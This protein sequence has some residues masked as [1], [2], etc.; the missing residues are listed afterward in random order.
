VSSGVCWWLKKEEESGRQ[1]QRR[2]YKKYCMIMDY[3]N[4]DAFRVSL[5]LLAVICVIVPATAEMHCVGDA[6]ACEEL[7]GGDEHATPWIIPG[8]HSHSHSSHSHSHAHSSS[9]APRYYVPINA[10]VGDTLMFAFMSGAHDVASMISE[11]SYDYCNFTDAVF[12]EQIINS[13]IIV[14]PQHTTL[15]IN[16][17]DPGVHFFAC[18]FGFHCVMQQKIIV[19]VSGDELSSID[20]PTMDAEESP[21]T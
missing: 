3:L 5:L 14:H 9:T 4:A 15:Y 13:D 12:N 1:A 20:G 17:M 16:L 10:T 11:E 8:P 18:S 7:Q 6:E 21:G 19:N 2:Q